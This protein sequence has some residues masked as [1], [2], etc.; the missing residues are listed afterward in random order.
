[1]IYDEE[2]PKTVEHFAKL[3]SMK[4]FDL[5]EIHIDVNTVD[6]MNYSQGIKFTFQGE[7]NPIKFGKLNGK[8]YAKAIFTS[9]E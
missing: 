4:N 2:W 1:M 3:F 6:G 9:S 5:Q 8:S 7:T